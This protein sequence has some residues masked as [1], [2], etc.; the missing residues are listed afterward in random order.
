MVIRLLMSRMAY[1]EKADMVQCL[2]AGKVRL[3]QYHMY[4]RCKYKIN[5]FWVKLFNPQVN[6][7]Q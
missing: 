5:P 1:E 7:Q 4:I 6:N 3:H 2:D